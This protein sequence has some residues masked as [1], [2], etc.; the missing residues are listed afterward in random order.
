[1]SNCATPSHHGKGFAF[2]KLVGWVEPARVTRIKGRNP[3][4]HA[5]CLRL[6]SNMFRWV[7]AA[8]C[9]AIS[10]GKRGLYPTYARLSNADNRRYGAL[11]FHPDSFQKLS[12]VRCV[13]LRPKSEGCMRLNSTFLKY[14]RAALL[15]VVVGAIVNFV[16]ALP[17]NLEHCRWNMMPPKG[18]FMH[19]PPGQ[20][21]PA[22]PPI[23]MFDQSDCR[24][25]VHMRYAYGGLAISGIVFL[26]LAS[27]IAWSSRK[28]A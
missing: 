2:A 19:Y 25:K 28:T 6:N 22:E 8:K 5:R 23:R 1:M 18:A 9:V 17:K 26:L 10:H 24:L 13:R 15:S 4:S 27:S 20:Y 12:A 16:G 3:T 21:A 7:S 14:G 11:Y